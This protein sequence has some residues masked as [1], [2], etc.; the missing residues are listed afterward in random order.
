MGCRG[1]FVI[2][3]NGIN[4][5]LYDR[6]FATGIMPDLFYG[7]DSTLDLLSRGR[8]RG[9]ET[10]L[11]DVWGEGGVIVDLDAKVLMFW[12]SD[13]LFDNVP[14]IPHLINLME[15]F[16]WKGWDVRHAQ[17]G[18]S[19]MGQYLD[20]PEFSQP[21]TYQKVSAEPVGATSSL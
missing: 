7:L 4:T 16:T 5:Y 6:S 8:D 21:V 1:S 19:S 12:G 9:D 11:D 17:W 15:T 2:R 14:L 3:K 13:V 10:I 20:L 18:M